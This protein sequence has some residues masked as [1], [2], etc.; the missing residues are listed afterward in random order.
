MTFLVVLRLVSGYNTNE[1]DSAYLIEET[2]RIRQSLES[3]HGAKVDKLWKFTQ[4]RF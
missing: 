2:D 4:N 3:G 1:D